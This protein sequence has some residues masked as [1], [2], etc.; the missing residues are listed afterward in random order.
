MSETHF[1]NSESLDTFKLQLLLSQDPD[2][3][4]PNK[5]DTWNL[6]G[7]YIQ[8]SEG[9]QRS[10]EGQRSQSEAGQ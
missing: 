4:G 8:G 5:A 9:H 10:E 7:S 6:G 2:N 3:Q 1:E